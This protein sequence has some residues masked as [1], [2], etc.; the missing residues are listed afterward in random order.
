[1]LEWDLDIQVERKHSSIV[2]KSTDSGL[3]SDEPSPNESAPSAALLSSASGGVLVNSDALYLVS[4][5]STHGSHVC[6][7]LVA[8]CYCQNCQDQ[9]GYYW[10]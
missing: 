8:D 6:R 3:D 9:S 4:R 10:G 7:A 1:M 2:K 5:D